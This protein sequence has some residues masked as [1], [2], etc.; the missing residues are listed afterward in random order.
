MTKKLNTRLKLSE[1]RHHLQTLWALCDG[2]PDVEFEMNG[3]KVRV[4]NVTM[5]LGSCEIPTE[6]GAP[7]LM[8]NWGE[9]LLIQ[10]EA[11]DG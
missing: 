8:P 1:F 6:R 7:A 5:T 4:T 2:D 10:L 9:T 11:T 3:S